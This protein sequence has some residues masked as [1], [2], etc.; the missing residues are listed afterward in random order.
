MLDSLNPEQ[1]QAVSTT[2][3]PL[4]VLAGAG[5]GKTRVITYRIAHLMERGVAPESILAVTFTNKATGEMKERVR[6]IVGE[7]DP[8]PRIS[9]FHSLGLSILR[10]EAESIGYRPNFSIYDP[11]DSIALL[12][13]I[14]R[15]LVTPEAN[16]SPEEAFRQISWAKT[17]FQTADD[18]SR[19]AENPRERLTARAYALYTQAMAAR[20]ALDFD[21]LIFRSV[22]LL[23]SN[24]AVRGAYRDRFRY[25]LV[26][27]YQDTNTS[28]YRFLKA[29]AGDNPNLC[30]VGDDDQSIYAFRGANRE[31]ILRFAEDYPDARVIRLERN[32]RST[33][34]ILKLA[35][36]VIALS[37]GRHKKSLRSVLGPGEPVRWIA[38][39]DSEIEARSI[40]TDIRKRRLETGL[41]LRAFAV[42]V[43]STLQARPLEERFRLENM[44]YF[45]IGG[46]SWFSRKEIRDALA[47]W[48]LIVNPDDE[49]AFLRIAN[50]PKRGVGDTS[51]KLITDE[52]A[53][54]KVAAPR[55]LGKFESL[56]ELPRR[57]RTSL[58]ALHE[59]LERAR[60]RLETS[61]VDAT[62]GI[63]EEVNY[64]GALRE[65]YDDP[66]TATARWNSVETLIQ[67]V[68]S[69]TRGSHGPGAL[70]GYL[71][72]LSVNTDRD[73]S[74]RF[75]GDAL[76]IITLHSAKGLE[77]PIVYLPGVDEGLLPHRRSAAEGEDG[78]DEERRLF[79]VGITR[80]Q[81]SLTILTAENRLIRG[82]PKVMTPSR[83][84]TELPPDLIK[85]EDAI[86][87]PMPREEG[88]AYLK[89]LLGDRLDS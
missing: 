27:E 55:L 60:R 30:V 84:L 39:K 76:G 78:I 46:Q 21:D 10:R 28:Q 81:K 13:V 65:L 67:S 44:P 32:Y 51:L 64:E 7:P 37:P 38:L 50:Y 15:D 75:K 17:H 18:E 22:L 19:A 63:L 14:L 2:E 53:R 36:A 71:Q 85:I 59:V 16:L 74:D 43:R 70:A 20:N 29:L 3:G 26:D 79:Y 88:L 86:S 89:E 9:T 58:K 87:E 72:A 48:S 42:L 25:L 61:I 73:N 52:A 47:Y 56:E 66:L 4:L 83:F 40:V 33:E 45:L 57:T 77:F 34:P 68:A 5:T 11:S 80:A 6:E 35:N 49:G 24:D 23:G 82:R 54:R 69:S 62:R 1:R 12:R 41:P 31:L 8:G